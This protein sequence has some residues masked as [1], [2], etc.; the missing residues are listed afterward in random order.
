M[1]FNDIIRGRIRPLKVALRA[2]RHPNYRLFFFGQGVSL[3]GTWM[4]RTAMAWLVY[5]L[6]GSKVL[7]GV[8][9]FAGMLPMSLLTPLAGVISDRV[10]RRPVLI[11]TQ[12]L[13][14]LQAFVLAALVVA[15][16]IRPS[17]IIA[18]G[19][20]LG[21][22]TAFDMPVRHAFVVEMIDDRRDL[23]NAIALNSLMFNAARFIGPAL[24]GLLIK[25]YGEGPVF[26]VNGLSFLAVIF[27]Y[28]A[29][30][31][32]AR[33]RRAAGSHLLGELAEGVL[34]V[35]RSKPMR[36]VL[37]LMAVMSLVSMPYLTLMPVFARDVLGG[38]AG[39]L[40]WL[41]TATGFGA[42]V[43]AAYLA[44]RTDMSR[45]ARR[46]PAAAVLLGISLAAF[47]FS[48]AFWLSILLLL[49]VGFSMMVLIAASNTVVQLMVS[50]DKR[51][52]VMGLFALCFQGVAPFGHLLAGGLAQRI[53]AP[54]TL[55]IDGIACVLGATV[56]LAAVR[57][58]TR[59]ISPPAPTG[60]LPT[61]VAEGIEAASTGPPSDPLNSGQSPIK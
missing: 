9:A 32:R 6:T 37:M 44:S 17:H 34:Y 22:T 13:A 39:T 7:L 50:D 38:G 58:V 61:E 51:G 1:T 36:A 43:G 20:F 57:S 49:V 31:T 48:R 8:V 59:T 60:A 40:G 18:L 47:A 3:I 33:E 26:A 25:L 45:F 56:F 52:R 30:R 27:S 14:M 2:L 21:L 53:G 15:D 46:I 42:I 54:T 5:R 24:A 28:F 23:G 55:F 16:V 10:S 11:L 4:Q 35:F 12:S 41:M 19:V 29:M